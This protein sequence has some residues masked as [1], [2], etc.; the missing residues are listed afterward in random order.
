MNRR[1]RIIFATLFIAILGGF[2]WIALTPTDP[3][4]AGKPLSYWMRAYCLTHD[5]DP[6]S[7]PSM[8]EAN[9]ALRDIRT[10]AIPTLLRMLRVRD[11]DLRFRFLALAKE[12]PFVKIYYVPALHLN[13]AATAG[14]NLLGAKASNS[15]PELI[16]IYKA[17]GSEES[18][19]YVAY[20]LGRIGPAAEKALPLLLPGITNKDETFR[21]YHLRAIGEIHAQ[22]KLAVPPIMTCLTNLSTPT[23]IIA[24]RA[25]GEYGGDANA[26][27]PQLL[28]AL[29]DPNYSIR[30]SATNALKKID[31]EAAA[32][33]GIK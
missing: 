4:Y 14:F 11:S 26:A 10:D 5:P 20:A 8:E 32:K 2:A 29:K 6:H 16:E 19:A 9:E 12:Q 18:S 13:Y 25:L 21:I 22:P 3:V 33:A 15:V 23:R 31:P 17:H 7:V 30:N 24:I 28:E 27:V 1:R